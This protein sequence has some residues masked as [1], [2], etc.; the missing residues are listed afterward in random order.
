MASLV[1]A[2]KKCGFNISRVVFE[3]M[4]NEEQMRR[5]LESFE[6]HIQQEDEEAARIASEK[7]ERMK[8]EKAE[9]GGDE[10]AVARCQIGKDITVDSIRKLKILLKKNSKLH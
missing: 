8:K 7:M 2:L 9:S 5:E 4:D 10:N 6:A 3:T 1:Q